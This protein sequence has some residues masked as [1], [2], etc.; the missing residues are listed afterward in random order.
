M[1]AVP[2]VPGVR[3]PQVKPVSVFAV[4]RVAPDPEAFV[5][6]MTFPGDDGVA[7]TVAAAALALIALASEAASAFT[8]SVVVAKSMLVEKCVASVAPDK[9]PDRLPLNGAPDTIVVAT[10][11]WLPQSPLAEAVM[12][13]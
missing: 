9:P 8:F 3:V 7:V 2:S 1:L 4:V 11:I 12:M 10:P 13:T 6:T 5:V